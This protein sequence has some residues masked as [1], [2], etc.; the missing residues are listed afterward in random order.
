MVFS[1][2]LVHAATISTFANGDSEVDV[3][4]REQGTWGDD[5]TAGISM[6]AGETVNAAGFIVG[7][8]YAEHDDVQVIDS[9]L[10]ANGE[11]WNPLYNGGMTQFSSGI[12]FTVDQEY[13]K[14][15]SQGF[16]ADFE[17][18]P[19]GWSAGPDQGIQPLIA[20][21]AHDHQD[22]NV[23]STGCGV[24]DW[25]WGT[26]FENPD[27]TA[28]LPDGQFEMVLTSASFFVHPGKADLS[29]QSFHSLFYREASEG[30]Q[31]YYYDDCAYVAVQNSTNDVD[32]QN[33]VFAPIDVGATT[34]VSVGDGM[35]QLGTSVNQVPT[36]RCDY[37]GTNG[38]GDGAL[39]RRT[40]FRVSRVPRQR[41]PPES[42]ARSRR[43][44][45]RPCTESPASR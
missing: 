5:L 10:V 15:T 3:E 2:T 9:S 43:W 25:C 44:G 28:S 36:N 18:N 38:R 8:D 17:A 39:P 26:D 7:T 4:L 14:L 11:I 16:N 12:D 23:L 24:G 22:N 20:N 42:A 34:G 35:Y 45:F 37:L 41:V 1:T 27:Y 40:A 32:F 13:L 30:S 33:A 19:E 6:P 31:T 21:W 29:F